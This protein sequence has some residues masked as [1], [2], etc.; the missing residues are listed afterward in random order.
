MADGFDYK[1]TWYP[2]AFSRDIAL[3]SITPF[4]VYDDEFILLRD[5]DENLTCLRDR[6]P[7]RAA[8]LSTGKMQQGVIECQYHGWQFDMNG[9][10]V[11]IPQLEPGAAIPQR[12]CVESFQVA[13]LQ[14]LVWFWYGNREQANIAQV[15]TVPDLESG[16]TYSVDYVVD[17]PYDQSYLIENVIDVAHIHIAHHDIRGGGNRALALPLQFTIEHNSVHG[18]KAQFRSIGLPENTNSPLKAALV[19]F[20]APNLI[21]YTSQYKDASLISGLALYSL[22]LGQQRCRLLYRKYSNF[23]S[24]KERRKPRWLEHYNQN[25][26]LQQDMAIIIGQHQAIERSNAE[27]NKLWLPIK[28]SDQLVLAYRR[29]LDEHGKNLPFYRGYRSSRMPALAAGADNPSDSYQIHTRQC[30]DCRKV[31]AR[32]LV[33]MMVLKWSLLIF[34]LSAIYFESTILKHTAL[35]MSVLSIGAIVGLSRFR[36]LFE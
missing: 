4:S 22:P 10:C 28:T 13:I 36:K 14:G 29:W 2:I 1:N 6:C 8:K 15:P 3:D 16:D 19:E 34:T 23:F 31:H 25:T 7:H 30:A 18:I 35:L 32:S 21:H 27:L 5:G 11:K 9:K 20:V 24:Q 12:A 33:A 26:I 17:L